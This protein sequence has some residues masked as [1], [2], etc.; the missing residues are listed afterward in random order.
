M[1]AYSYK[2][3]QLDEIRLFNKDPSPHMQ[4]NI[5]GSLITVKL[6]QAGRYLRY[7]ALSYAWGDTATD[8]S[9]LTE[10]I[11]CEGCRLSVTPNLKQALVRIRQL[12]EAQTNDSFSTKSKM[13]APEHSDLITSVG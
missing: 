7:T 2:S 1:A 8:G 4:G 11:I 5:R 6:L 9:H 12:N 13:E 3:L 10:H